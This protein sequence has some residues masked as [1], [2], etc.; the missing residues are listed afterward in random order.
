M[1]RRVCFWLII[2]A[3]VV[4]FAWRALYFPYRPARLYRVIPPSATFITEHEALAD[5]WRT[6]AQNP[7]VLGSTH[8][9]GVATEDID[10]ILRSPATDRI[11]RRFASR[12]TIAA[13]T[14]GLAQPGRPAWVL[15]SWAGVQGQFL[16]WGFY[17][18]VMSDFSRVDIDRGR[19][20]WSLAMEED[21]P[22][23][24]LSL[25][26]VEGVL[27]CC[28]S[29][30]PTGVRFLIERIE[31]GA[32]LARSLQAAGA[33]VPAPFPPELI[34]RGWIVWH[35]GMGY[36]PSRAFRYGFTAL[37]E[38]GTAGWIR[39]DFAVKGATASSAPSL[40]AT[41]TVER[42][43]GLSTFLGDAPAS[44]AVVPFAG[45]APYLA[46]DSP[47]PG[48]GVVGWLVNDAADP[49]GLAFA[50]L[51]RTE[52]QGRILGI[53][54]PTALVGIEIREPEG[55]LELASSALDSLN[56]RYGFGLIP[57]T[58][59][60][61]D[62]PVV[63]LAP[64]SSGRFGTLGPGERPAL[65]LVDNWLVLCSNL[66]ALGALLRQRKFGTGDHGRLINLLADS[67][68]SAYAWLDLEASSEVFRRVLALYDL[69]GYARGAGG[70]SG[71]GREMMDVLK[72]WI[73]NAGDMST[74]TL[75][76]GVVGGE[77]VIHFR[78]GE[79]SAGETS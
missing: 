15:A 8:A 65:T 69:L 31:R 35:R 3:A 18:S 47:R 24:H 32:P 41:D 34:H 55:M 59:S 43:Q 71:P 72:N 17:S 74:L 44:L 66:D 60:V 26:V 39:G 7:V 50:C 2:P 54:A 79:S 9:L 33:A 76:W 13:Y 61:H 67:D 52:Y 42:V 29:D 10:E 4:L 27:L 28:L 51:C 62:T 20:C 77:P 68:G 57:E 46:G 37:T 78:L 48:L 14:P 30:D 12:R 11:L 6:C 16:R 1:K 58:V 70:A 53:S 49:D 22:F 38:R 63:V 23:S 21:A 64:V 45:L 73:E 19:R 75:Q 40:S 36:G 56:A 5:N 25:A